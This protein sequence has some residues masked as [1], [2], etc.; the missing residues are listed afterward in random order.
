MDLREINQ[1]MNTNHLTQEQESEQNVE[2]LIDKIQEHLKLKDRKEAISHILF[3]S[4]YTLDKNG[5][6]KKKDLQ[7]R[8]ER[9]IRIQHRTISQLNEQLSSLKYVVFFSY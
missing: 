6:L 8:Y 9:L 4:G 5:Q 3:E 7:Q 2:E 1:Y